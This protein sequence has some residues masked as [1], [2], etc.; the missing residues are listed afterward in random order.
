MFVIN[1]AKSTRYL[2]EP[3]IN[4]GNGGKLPISINYFY[5]LSYREFMEI[6]FNAPLAPSTPPAI[7]SLPDL[8]RKKFQID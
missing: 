1:I 6:A 3:Y 4:G 2:P 7:V 5:I 8:L